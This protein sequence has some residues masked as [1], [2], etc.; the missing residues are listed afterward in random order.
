MAYVLYSIDKEGARE[1]ED[2]L[3]GAFAKKSVE[4]IIEGEKIRDMALIF[5]KKISKRDFLL[6]Q[7]ILLRTL[8]VGT[9][10]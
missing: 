6:L 1:I 10:T 4:Y 5:D 9:Q 2:Y 7:S 3:K 8:K